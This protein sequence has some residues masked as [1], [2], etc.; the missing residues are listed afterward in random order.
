MYYLKVI[1]Y[2]ILF[3]IAFIILSGFKG[4]DEEVPRNFDLGQNNPNTFNPQTKIQFDVFERCKLLIS[5]YDT[6]GTLM[7]TLLNNVVPAGSYELNWD[8]SKY[9]S[10]V[11]YIMLSSGGFSDAKRMVLL[12]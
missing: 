9:A 3:F 10:G 8:G 6:K 11:Y 4:L 12:K 7:C 1:R 2:C 5:V